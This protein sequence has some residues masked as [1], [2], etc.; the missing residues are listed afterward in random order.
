MSNLE[1]NFWPPEDFFADFPGAFF[2]APPFSGA[3]EKASVTAIPASRLLLSIAV[4]IQFNGPIGAYS[5]DAYCGIRS[6]ANLAEP[7]SAAPPSSLPCL[8]YDEHK[9]VHPSPL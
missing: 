5:R 3:V 1:E 9:R 2:T 7:P 8:H 6:R 4:P